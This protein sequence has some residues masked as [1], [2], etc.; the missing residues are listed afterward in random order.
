MV[1][2]FGHEGDALAHVLGLPRVIALRQ[3]DSTMDAAHAAAA[4]GAP[5][6]T[7][8]L[9][10][11]QR[12]GRGRGGKSW[13]SAARQGIW[14]TLIERPHSADGL[15]VLSL[16]VGL[17]LAPALERRG[18]LA[19]RLKWPN[20]LFVD[21]AKLAGVLIEARWRQARCDW[22]AIGLGL[23]LSDAAFAGAA[24]VRG[25]D[26]ADLLAE[27]VPALRA[28]AFATGPLRDDELAAFAA[29]DLALGLALTAPAVGTARGIQSTGELLV[30]TAAGVTPYRTG[31]LVL[32]TT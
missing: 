14:M 21:G 10:E 20:D 22:V 28:A 5:A 23:N 2:W 17:H 24:A 29:R 1:S 12:V 4:E 25:T 32:A 8:V 15:D 16:R 11:E 7:L 13:V 18:G 6:G 19:I 27:I 30:E 9:A 31:S 3:V 26:P